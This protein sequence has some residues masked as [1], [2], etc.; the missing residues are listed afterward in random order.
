M[1]RAGRSMQRWQLLH[2]Q[3]RAA[4]ST[5]D[6]S[7]SARSP[8][9]TIRGLDALRGI[10]LNAEAHTQRVSIDGTLTFALVRTSI[11]MID[12]QRLEVLPSP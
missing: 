8:P 10:S 3:A 7:T 9:K 5:N 1:L 6:E 4:Y 12:L 2:R 11:D